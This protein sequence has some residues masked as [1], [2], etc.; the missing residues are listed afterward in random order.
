[1]IKV[2]TPRAYIDAY[3]DW[4]GLDNTNF[5][6]CHDLEDVLD[7]KIKIACVP[8]FFDQLTNPAVSFD[9]KQ[10]DLLIMSDIELHSVG[11]IKKW[12]DSLGIKNYLVALGGLDNRATAVGD[13][14]YRPWWTY[15]LMSNNKDCYVELDNK[16][17][18]FDILLGQRKEYR[19]WILAQVLSSGLDKTSL[20]SYRD[21][22]GFASKNT[23]D[24]PYPYVC[25]N[26]LPEFEVAETISNS[27]SSIVPWKIYEQT[28][29]TVVAETHA[30]YD[31]FFFSEKPTKA[32][33]ARRMFVAFSCRN[34][35]KRMREELGF[36]TF[37]NVIDESYDLE[38]DD[39]T[40]Y[41]KAFEQLKVLSSMD[42][43]T[44]QEQTR[45]VREHNYHRLY[46]LRQ[47]TEKQMLEKIQNKIS[48]LGT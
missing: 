22:F 8:V 45:E 48:G 35:L 33:F 4:I 13:F 31:S 30:Q 43:R 11:E 25:P 19:D 17:Y 28:K 3:I 41:A 47:D 9:Y 38:S 16:P 42:Y 20:C 40:R 27:V 36:R 34:Y 15:N 10:F 24:I 21:V 37:G 5:Q 14:V 39:Y 23:L 1:M 6:R 12:I 32:I 7:E 2:Y 29:Y 26:L 18:D 46:T 44:V